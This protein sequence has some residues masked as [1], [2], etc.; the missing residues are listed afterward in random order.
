MKKVSIAIILVF[1]MICFSCEKKGWFVNCSDCVADEP[2]KA[3]LNIK[4]DITEAPVI[5]KIYEGKL[6]DSIFLGS[7]TTTSSSTI[8]YE[9]VSFNIEYTATATYTIGGKKYVAVSSATPR[10]KYTEDQCDDACYF[11]YDNTLN[12]KLKDTAGGK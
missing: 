2:E 9:E 1:M 6:E 4:V 8:T 12:L 5:I 10:V 3:E 11:I 7:V